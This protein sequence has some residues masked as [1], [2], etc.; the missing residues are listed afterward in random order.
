MPRPAVTLVFSK[1]GPVEDHG[2]VGELADAPEEIE[3]PVV[4][5][6]EARCTCVEDLAGAAE[7]FAA[8]GTRAA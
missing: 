5:W 4:L 8:G 3:M 7:D 2:G 6:Q 1:V